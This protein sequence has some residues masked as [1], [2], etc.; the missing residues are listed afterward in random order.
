MSRS[1][2]YCKERNPNL[3]FKNAKELSAKKYF[4]KILKKQRSRIIDFNNGHIKIE[5]SF[6]PNADFNFVDSF[7]GERFG[8]FNDTEEQ[9]DHCVYEVLCTNAFVPY[10][11]F[12]EEPIGGWPVPG[13]KI[14]CIFGNIILINNIETQNNLRQHMYVLIP[15]KYKR[16]PGGL[17][18]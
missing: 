5:I 12:L 3:D 15:K 7:G 6:D 9:I 11:E 14:Q 10:E 18:E 1:L 2:E 13:D 16:I 8:F 4:D 17:H